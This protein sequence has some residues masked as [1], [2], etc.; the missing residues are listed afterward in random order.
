MKWRP[1]PG[2]V[3]VVIPAYNEAKTLEAIVARVEA[4][5]SPK[6]ILVAEDGS[7]DGTKEIAAR[8][9]REG[10]VVPLLAEKNGGKGMA[11]RRGLAAARGEVTIIQDA[12]LEYDPEEI[13]RVVAPILEG[14]LDVCYG[15]RIRGAAE[16]GETRR[17]SFAFYW[18]GRVV[19]LTATLLYLTYVT[20]EPTCYK[21]FRTASVRDIPL[22][23]TGFEVEPEIT[24]KVLR[25]GLRYGEVPISY[26]PRSHAEGKKIR[27]TDG[28]R[29]I[30]TLVTWRVRGF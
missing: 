11:F 26:H 12:D 22:E 1:V 6:E 24:A 14:R 19:S 10:R 4:I 8:L 5:P 7:T 20:D 3:T 16:R 2:L 13:P 30:A 18:G 25:S 23:G 27:W 17:S 28:V 21:A 9:G 29:A 15:S